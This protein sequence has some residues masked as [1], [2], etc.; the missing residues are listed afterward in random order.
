MI[1]RITNQSSYEIWSGP[2]PKLLISQKNCAHPQCKDIGHNASIEAVPAYDP[3][4]DEPPWSLCLR[5]RPIVLSGCGN[6]CCATLRFEP[7]CV[8]DRNWSDGDQLWHN[9][10]AP[11]SCLRKDL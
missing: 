2:E 11:S 3:T 4:A 9:R 6:P 10:D 7:W 5:L 1:E 8:V